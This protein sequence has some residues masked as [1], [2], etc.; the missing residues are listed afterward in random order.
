MAKNKYDVDESLDIQFNLE[1]CKR[2]LSYVKP[3]KKEMVI[4]LIVMLVSS[5]ASLM[6]PYL[7]KIA[8]D[9]NIPSK[10]MRGLVL[11]CIIFVTT[12]VISS[13][14]MKYKIKTMTF[15]GQSVVRNIRSDL[16]NHLQKLPF[17]YYDSRPHG[18]ILVRVV[19][20]VNSLS[21][22]LSNGLINLL[23]D[24]FSIFVIV[25]FMVF[26]S[27]K[28]TLIC[29][30]GMPILALVVALLAKVQRITTQRYS[31]KQSN[32]NAYIQESISGMKVTQAF[33][34][35]RVNAE[36]FK[37]VSGENRSTWMT[38]VKYQLM[39]WP[40]IDNISVFTVSLV[41]LVGI[42]A[43]G[44]AIT[45]GTLV[46][47]VGYIWRFWNPIVNISNFYNTLIMAMAYLE[48]IFET[49]DEEVSISNL[50][51]A[52]EM[53]SIEGN[54]EFKNVV[55]KY[56]DEEREILKNVSFKVNAG[57]TIALVGPTGAGKTTIINLLSRF[58]DVTKGEVII[59]NN[60]IRNVTL[61]SLREQMGVMLQDTFIF[62]GTILENIRY[63][64]LSATEEEIINASKA[65]RAH[66]FIINLKD[67]YNTQVNERGSRLSVGQRQLISFARALLADPKILILDEA[68]SSIDT[69]TEKALQ[70][71][72]DR[73]LKGRT[74][75]VIAHRLSTIKNADRIMVI[76]DGRIVE[77][78]T[79]DELI[80]N[81]GEYYNLYMAQYE[82]MNAV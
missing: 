42:K 6:G 24:L 20:Y 53:P 35:E 39:L 16:F 40:A 3:Y 8:M 74:S 15:V 13:I 54:I 26:I 47:F 31:N 34:R 55:F 30:I 29:M 66:E 82:I 41:Y 75:F 43:I 27:P 79:H 62:S 70:E 71:G 67:G 80:N 10:D 37:V 33:V 49:L 65:V 11:I 50:P 52:Y 4:T 28:L 45:I 1:Y 76:N 51:N 9:E 78:G 18:K 46:A 59:D 23:T 36:K 21:D 81:H 77:Q 25:G 5:I 61:S 48:R 56:E 58:Y 72:L 12:I 57:E 60:N 2:L 64:N 44:E 69:K 17:S 73:L 63:G 14:C 22:L 68:T 19:N 32:L 38:A 7:V